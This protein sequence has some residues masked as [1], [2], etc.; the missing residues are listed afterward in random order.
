L[1]VV[2]CN[3]D[4]ILN[5]KIMTIVKSVTL[6]NPNNEIRDGNFLMTAEVILT[7]GHTGEILSKPPPRPLAQPAADLIPLINDRPDIPGLANQPTPIA[8]IAPPSMTNPATMMPQ[9]GTDPAAPGTPS[10]PIANLPSQPILT[11]GQVMPPTTAQKG[12]LVKSTANYTPEL[13]QSTATCF[14][15]LNLDMATQIV[16][17]ME[18]PW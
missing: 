6:A 4:L 9:A 5:G 10:D 8:G 15:K 14:Q 13:G 11:N 17:L 7:D 12:V 16:H 3:A 18:K 2:D 1:K